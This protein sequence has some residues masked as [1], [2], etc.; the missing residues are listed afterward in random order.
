MITVGKLLDAKGHQVWSLGPEN[1]VY[2]AIALMDKK[3]VGAL[4]IMVEHSL[5]GIISERDYARKVI[6]KNRSSKATKI[7][8]I[9]STNVYH[10]KPEDPVEECLVMM[11]DL[12]VRHLP[13]LEGDEVVGLVSVGDIVKEIIREQQYTI[14]QLE[15]TISWQEAY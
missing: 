8:E 14:K 15:H 4:A 9:M 11:N 6:L 10:T 3:G 5:V 1:T 7:K 12:R 13:V 2:D